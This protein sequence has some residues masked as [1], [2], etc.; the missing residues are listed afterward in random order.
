MSEN[1]AL[2]CDVHAYSK[3][4]NEVYWYIS[5]SV[6]NVTSPRVCASFSPSVKPH[7]EKI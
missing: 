3:K 4:H 7:L 2:V 1:S 5:S 6:T